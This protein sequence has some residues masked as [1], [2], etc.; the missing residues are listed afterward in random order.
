MMLYDGLG[1][2]SLLNTSQP[3]EARFSSIGNPEINYLMV[4]T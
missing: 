1:M 2:I 4:W 3:H